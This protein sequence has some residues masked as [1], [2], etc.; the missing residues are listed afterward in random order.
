MDEWFGFIRT[1]HLHVATVPVD[2]LLQPQRHVSSK[3]NLREMSAKIEIGEW[4]RTALNGIQP[5]FHVTGNTG[6][7][8]GDVF[9]QGMVSSPP[10]AVFI[11]H[12]YETVG[13]P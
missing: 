12:L 5:F 7:A 10:E 3:A 11:I 2:I 9:G 13:V 1:D 8:H 4:F 6:Q